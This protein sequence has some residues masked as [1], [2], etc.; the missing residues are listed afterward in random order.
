MYP[1]LSESFKKKKK[2]NLDL[3]LWYFDNLLNIEEEED[4]SQR[5]CKQIT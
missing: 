5:Q 4:E 3:D 1:L 2:M